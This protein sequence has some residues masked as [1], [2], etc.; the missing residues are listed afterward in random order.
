MSIRLNAAASARRRNG[1]STGGGGSAG[2]E[3]WRPDLNGGLSAFKYEV[4]SNGANGSTPLAGYS[5]DPSGRVYRAVVPDGATDGVKFRTRFRDIPLADRQEIYFSMDIRIPSTMDFT[6]YPSKQ[7]WGVA[8]LP[9]SQGGWYTS[10]G[11]SKKIDSWSFRWTTIPPDYLAWKLGS[12]PLTFVA[13]LY[14]VYAN[15]EVLSQYGIEIPFRTGLNGKSGSFFDLSQNLDKWIPI[16]GRAVM[17]DPGVKNGMAEAW[18][19]NAKWVS[20]SDV[21]WNESGY[22]VPIN[23]VIAETFFNSGITPG[24]NIEHQNLVLKS[25]L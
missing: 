16:T 11:G 21:M 25:G 8:G 14:A 3:L 24:G 5:T 1:G 18:I 19:G 4:I 2:V 15:G 12:H 22:D 13:Y 7:T 17:N 23:Q 10:T 9:N 6:T 20:I